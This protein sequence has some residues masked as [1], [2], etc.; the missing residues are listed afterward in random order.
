VQSS[1]KQRENEESGRR[2]DSDKALSSLHGRSQSATKAMKEEKGEGEN[3]KSWVKRIA[4]Q[5]V[6]GANKSFCENPIWK[7]IRTKRKTT[8]W[9]IQ[10]QRLGGAFRER[11]GGELSRA[12]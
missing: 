4:D 1:G 9:M 5:A 10:M 8:A 2:K 12:I 6:L 11:A 7:G 3:K